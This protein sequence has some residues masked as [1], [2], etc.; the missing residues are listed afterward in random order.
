MSEGEGQEDVSKLYLEIFAVTERVPS[1]TV[2]VP[3]E[4]SS[5]PPRPPTPFSPDI[6]LGSRLLQVKSK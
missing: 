1:L 2:H 5:L 6:S 4:I 3:M